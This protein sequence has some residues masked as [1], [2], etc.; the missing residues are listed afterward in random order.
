MQAADE[1]AVVVGAA[2]A[3]AER[4]RLDTYAAV[5]RR[6]AP[7]TRGTSACRN[8]EVSSQVSSLVR[9]AREVMVAWYG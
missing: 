4:R 2:T 8:G 7:C 6:A 3:A 5:P 1:L 9:T